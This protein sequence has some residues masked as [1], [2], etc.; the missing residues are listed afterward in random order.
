[1]AV[2]SNTP[3]ITNVATEYNYLNSLTLAQGIHK[4]EVSD[5][6]IQ[7]YGRQDITGIMEMLGNT[8]AINNLTFTHYEQDRIHGVIRVGSAA[9][10]S[11]SAV[12][13]FT[14]ATAYN[15]TY[16]G[17]SPYATGDSFTSYAV[18]PYD[19]IEINGYQ[20]LVTATGAG[21]FS[22]L[23]ADPTVTRPAISTSD[24]IIILGTAMPE[25]STAPQSRNS[26]QLSYSNNLQIHR[27]TH[28]VTGTEMGIKTWVNYKGKDGQS[29]PF[30]YVEGIADE[31]LRTLN[32]REA[33]LLAGQQIT[34][35]AA[36]A[37][38]GSTSI[39]DFDSV[40]TTQGL[41]PQISANGNV[42]AYTSG[43]FGW[44]DIDNMVT[45]LQKYRGASENW[46]FCGHP[47]SLDISDFM[48]NGLSAATGGQ[49][50]PFI[51]LNTMSQG[52]NLDFDWFTRGKFRFAVKVVDAFSD[53]NFLGY[54]GG[55]Y[56]KLGIVV[57]MGNTVT[58]NSMNATTSVTVPTLRVNYLQNDDG[59]RYIR[60]WVTGYGGGAMSNGT[61]AFEVH[62]L[63]Q[64]GLEAFALN[65]FGIFVGS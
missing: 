4:P 1:M 53:P 34:N 10:A 41:I 52:L 23:A 57:P 58:Y 12:Q 43:A 56:G 22:A 20:Y 39:G 29:K 15:Y 7:R 18:Q 51:S 50:T 19:V 62:W 60:E 25:A 28:K 21:V 26:T 5:L 32:E 33:I 54:A 16:T 38:V 36:L 59:G 17:Q 65:R 2:T 14:A 8:N 40:S 24:D 9:S 44:S 63:S 3:S 61:D 6:F 11:G 35:K 47:L 45:N 49:A 30:W 31:Y 37:S 46:L 13:G 55:I 64:V 48:L 27:R 42:E